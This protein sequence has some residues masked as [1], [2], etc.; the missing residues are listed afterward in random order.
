MVT[1]KEALTAEDA[2]KISCYS[3]IDYAINEDAPV[4]DAV[5]MF[6]AYNIGCLVT[7]NSKGRSHESLDQEIA[8][9]RNATGRLMSFDYFLYHY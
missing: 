3:E 2:R 7:T 9:S 6:A 8:F 1:I 5:Q 4:L